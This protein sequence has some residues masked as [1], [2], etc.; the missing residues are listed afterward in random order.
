LTVK[1]VAAYLQLHKL[2]VYRY[3][4]DGQLPASRVGKA[5]R[6]R[7]ADLDAFLERA[8]TTPARPAAAPRPAGPPASQREVVAVATSP[9]PTDLRY[10]DLT[11]NPIEWVIRNLH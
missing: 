6:I 8:R 7:R 1:Q 10:R 5:Y 2:T 3:I 11:V 4:R 9:G